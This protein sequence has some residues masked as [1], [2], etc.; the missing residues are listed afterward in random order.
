MLIRSQDKTVLINL[1]SVEVMNM[2]RVEDKYRIIF[3]LKGLCEQP[4]GEYETQNQALKVLDKLQC[5]YAEPTYSAQIA[6]NET[7]TYDGK[8]FDMPQVFE[9]SDIGFKL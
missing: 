9:V 2:T 4:M 3:Y 8:V 7:A 5:F 6:E 1:D